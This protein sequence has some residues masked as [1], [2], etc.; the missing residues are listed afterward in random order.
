MQT[1]GNL[2]RLSALIAG[3]APRIASAR[4]KDGETMLALPE[5][6]GDCLYLYLVTAGSVR[7][8]APPAEDRLVVAPAIIVCRADRAHRIVP[9]T[10]DAFPG[11]LCLTVHFD[12]PVAPLFYREFA[13]PCCL[14]LLNAEPTLR[15]AINL[16]AGELE[17]PRCGQPTLLD[18]A[19]DILLIALLRHLIAHATPPEGLFCALADPRIARALVAMHETPQSPWTLERLAETSGMSR[20]LFATTFHRLMCQPPGKYLAKLRL[21]IAQRAVDAGKGLK[22]A[23]RDAGYASPAALSR[24]L[25]RHRTMETLAG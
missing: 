22:G 16:I 4:A 18:R 12:G 20:T 15:H 9:H 19:G 13:E 17:M 23:A 3:L 5:T 14:P 25:A 11:L 8:A 21:T 2:D 7:F 24:A 10:L 1:S 6:T